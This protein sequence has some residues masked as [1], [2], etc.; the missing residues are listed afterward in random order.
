MKDTKEAK[1]ILEIL[2]DRRIQ[3]INPFVADNKIYEKHGVKGYFP[4]TPYKL[5]RDIWTKVMNQLNTSN[6]ALFWI[7]EDKRLPPIGH[8]MTT[9]R[10]CYAEI[11]EAVNIQHRRN[12]QNIP[13]IIQFITKDKHPLI[14]WALCSPNQLYDGIYEFEHFRQT[15][16]K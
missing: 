1:R 5:G 8:F 9:A 2:E 4:T 16:W 10:G 6:M 13:Y 7:P 12:R 15:R 3:I 11:Q 14:A